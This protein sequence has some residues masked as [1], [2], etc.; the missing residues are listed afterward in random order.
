MTN[1]ANLFWTHFLTFLQLFVKSYSNSFLVK[2]N[3]QVTTQLIFQGKTDTNELCN[4]YWKS[5]YHI[6]V[7]IVN[8]N[9]NSFLARKISGITNWFI[10]RGNTGT[11]GFL[12]FKNILISG[13]NK[14]WHS[15][16]TKLCHHLIKWYFKIYAV[17]SP[18]V[19][20]SEISVL[21]K[22]LISNRVIKKKKSTK[23]LSLSVTKQ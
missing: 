20:S 19:I 11:I 16:T 8:Q 14:L 10:N 15:L 9:L 22:T 23:C 1:F 12:W 4:W 6:L 3:S 18:S 13:H 21:R 7:R 5:F 2:I 17:F